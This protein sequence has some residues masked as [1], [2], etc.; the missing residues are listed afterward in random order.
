MVWPTVGFHCRSVIFL[1][2]TMKVQKWKCVKP[3]S[4]PHPMDL[5]CAFWITTIPHS[6]LHEV[7]YICSK[8]VLAKCLYQSFYPWAKYWTQP[9]SVTR[10]MKDDIGK[11]SIIVMK[12]GFNS[13]LDYHVNERIL[14]TIPAFV[15]GKYT[16]CLIT[17]TGKCWDMVGILHNIPSIYTG[18]AWEIFLVLIRHFVPEYLICII[19]R[20]SQ[21]IPSSVSPFPVSDQTP[22]KSSRN[23]AYHSQ[24]SYWEVFPVSDQTFCPS[25]PNLHISSKF[26]ADS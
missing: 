8:C 6:W 7:R 4:D 22:G 3:D 12:M 10:W 19:R 17:R 1:G 16:Q 5:C 26:P 24:Y 15:L 20:I 23:L 2:K 13:V 11:K 21:W 14:P 25:K 9:W 18:K